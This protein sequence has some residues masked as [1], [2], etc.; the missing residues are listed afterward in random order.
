MS[1]ISEYFFWETM[2]ADVSS[3]CTSCFHCAV[4]IGGRRNPR[5]FGHASHSDK[6][7][8]LL[9]FDLMFMG[10]S[11]SGEEYVLVMKDDAS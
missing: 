5:P 11:T 3:F 7:N 8:E 6:P 10:G 1:A 4:T 2:D 9:H